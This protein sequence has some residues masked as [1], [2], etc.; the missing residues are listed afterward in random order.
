MKFFFIMMR[1]FLLFSLRIGVFFFWSILKSLF[2]V[3]VFLSVVINFLIFIVFI[4]ISWGGG[5]K[6]LSFNIGRILW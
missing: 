6:S 5:Y 1:N 3:L 2:I 4:K